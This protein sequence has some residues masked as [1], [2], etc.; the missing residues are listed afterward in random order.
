M[1]KIKDNVNLKKLNKFGFK[2]YKEINYQY[3]RYEYNKL[4]GD[5]LN[6]IVIYS[7]DR[8]IIFIKR[9]TDVLFDLITAGLVEKVVEE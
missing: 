1:L 5:K 6:Q 7:K 8:E 4:I 9:G 2:H 3:E